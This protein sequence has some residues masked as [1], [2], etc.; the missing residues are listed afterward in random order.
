MNQVA[1]IIVAFVAALGMIGGVV[2]IA[3][4]TAPQAEA[5]C[6]KGF[7]QSSVGLNASKGR[8]FRP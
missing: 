6:E 4:A 2:L 5:G 7:P 3:V 8:C 1:I